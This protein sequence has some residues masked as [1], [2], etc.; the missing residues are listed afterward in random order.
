[1]DTLEWL[2]KWLIKQSDGNWEHGCGIQMKTLNNSGWSLEV[3]L[4]GTD[5]FLPDKEWELHESGDGWY[6]YEVY[7]NTFKSSGD[8]KKLN[9]L[10]QLF[11]EKITTPDVN[12]ILSNT[13]EWLEN[14]YLQQCN[15]YW[16]YSYGIKIETLDNPGWYLV[17]EFIGTNTHLQNEGWKNKE[18]EDGWCAYG[19]EDGVFSATCDPNKLG[20]LIQLFKEKVTPR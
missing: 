20:L 3:E 9:F 10:I 17:I 6:G 8:P 4:D 13:L 5:L 19:I 14:W 11:K 1:M 18:D 15:G 12:I 2:E 16:E 7:D